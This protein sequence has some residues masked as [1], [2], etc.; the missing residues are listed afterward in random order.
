MNDLCD[1]YSI[2]LN[3]RIKYQ[4]ISGKGIQRAALYL[5]KVANLENVKNHGK[6]DFLVILGELR[7]C[8]VHNDSYPKD[9]KQT[10]EFRE[11]LFISISSEKKRYL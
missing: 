9:Q 10:K 7:N 8:I 6:W 1:A 2:L 11:K 5:K 4:D 3:T